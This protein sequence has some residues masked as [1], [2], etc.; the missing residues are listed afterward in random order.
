MTDEEVVVILEKLKQEET[1]RLEHD[2]KL[3]PE[4]IRVIMRKTLIK[5]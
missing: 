5:E 3:A 4:W 1:Y 2:I